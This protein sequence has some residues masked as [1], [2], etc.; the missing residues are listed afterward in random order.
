MTPYV[1][2]MAAISINLPPTIPVVSYDKLDKFDK[3]DELD[4][5]KIPLGGVQSSEIL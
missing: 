5:I 1:T 3:L 4:L 2:K